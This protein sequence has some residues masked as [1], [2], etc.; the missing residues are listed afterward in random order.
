MFTAMSTAIRSRLLRL[1]YLSLG[2]LLIWAAVFVSIAGVFPFVFLLLVV[3]I[4]AT[5]RTKTS[6]WFAAVPVVL[7]G[8]VFVAVALAMMPRSI[9]HVRDQLIPV[10]L[11]SSDRV[12][13]IQLVQLDPEDRYGC[14][15]LREGLVHEVTDRAA[16]RRLV[17]ALHATSPYSPNHEGIREPWLLNARTSDGGDVSVVLGRSSA[18][19]RTIGWVEFRLAGEVVRGSFDYQNPRIRPAL[20]ELGFRLW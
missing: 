12:E 13:S 15:P 17:A 10:M 11:L 1:T 20:E 8:L 6:S 19:S 9:I 14:T 3:G 7:G 16:I 4:F 5:T 2:A 18:S